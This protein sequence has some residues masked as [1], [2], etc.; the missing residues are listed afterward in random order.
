MNE[1]LKGKKAVIFDFDGTLVYTGEEMACHGNYALRKMG[2]PE[3]KVSYYTAYSGKSHEEFFGGILEEAFG[4]KDD[5]KMREFWRLYEEDIERDPYG[6]SLA[7]KFDGIDEMLTGLKEMGIK[8]AVYSNNAA[9]TVLDILN[10]LFGENYFDYIHGWSEGEAFKPNPAG[11][12]R[13]LEEMELK[14]DECIYVGDTEVDIE[15][16]KNLGIVTAAAL[17]GYRT[18]ETLKP[19]HPDVFLKKPMDIIA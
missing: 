19:Y 14:P 6:N 12:L 11:G 9:E 17:W 2:L 15:T 3:A 1:L 13:I 16:G 10:R 18:E 8:T 7:T 5:D 4:I